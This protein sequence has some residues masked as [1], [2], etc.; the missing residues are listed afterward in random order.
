[1]DTSLRWGDESE[2]SWYDLS[3]LSWYEKSASYLDRA[4]DPV[5]LKALRDLTQHQ[6]NTTP[7]GVV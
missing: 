5:I 3:G 2:L 6:F 1:M 7:A 4:P